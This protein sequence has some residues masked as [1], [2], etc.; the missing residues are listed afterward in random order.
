MPAQRTVSSYLKRSK[1]YVPKSK[2]KASSKALVKKSHDRG[3]VPAGKS[4][5][6]MLEKYSPFPSTRSYT[7]SY[8]NGA[9]LLTPGT[10]TVQYGLKCNSLFDIDNNLIAAFG[11]HSPTD[12]SKLLSA[13]GPY[14][15]YRVDSWDI[16]I[17]LINQSASPL[18]GYLVGSSANLTDWDTFNECALFPPAEPF[19]MSGVAGNSGVKTIKTNGNFKDI[20]TFNRDL[21]TSAAYNTDPGILVYGGLYLYS[22]DGTN[23]TVSIACRIRQR[24]VLSNTDGSA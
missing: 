24:A 21:A 6:A 10:A 20:Y 15:D 19:Y 8:E 4:R 22:T 16:E 7:F 11:N 13:T 1:P 23:I 5:T 3:I 12:F 2:K 17:T 9:T 18:A 14:R